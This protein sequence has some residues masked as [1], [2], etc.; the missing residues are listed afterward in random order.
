MNYIS[1]F[2][3]YITHTLTIEGNFAALKILKTGPSER[4]K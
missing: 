4:K 3:N 1:L 2:I